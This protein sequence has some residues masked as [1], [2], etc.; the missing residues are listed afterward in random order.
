MRVKDKIALCIFGVGI[1]IVISLVIKDAIY[2]KNHPCS[3]KSFNGIIYRKYPGKK[4][5]FIYKVKTSMKPFEICFCD[6][7]DFEKNVEVG[8]TIVKLK[9]NDSCLVF[10]KEKKL[11]V[12]YCGE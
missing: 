1:T 7:T 12:L 3:Q 8:D 11:K 4:H 9:D 10:N 6:H 5:W 2:S